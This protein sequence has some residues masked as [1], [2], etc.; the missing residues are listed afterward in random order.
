MSLEQYCFDKRP[1][2]QSSATSVSD[3]ILALKS[4]HVG[5]VIVEE[6]ARL[7][8]IVTDRDLA[9][10]VLGAK[11]EPGSMTLHDVMTPAPVTLPI[12]ASESQVVKL[13][14]AHHIR[15]IPIVDGTKVA[16]IV[17]LDDLLMSGAVNIENAGA[18]IEAQLM[19]PAANKP[20]G[21]VYPMRLPPD[22]PEQQSRARRGARAQP[23][24]DEFQ[25]LLRS[26]LGMTDP[27]RARTAFEIVV[28]ALTR[29]VTEEET[30]DLVARLPWALKRQLRELTHDASASID[31]DDLE[32]ELAHRLDLDQAAANRMLHHVVQALS[33]LLG[34]SEL[35]RLAN[36]V[37]F[38]LKRVLT[39]SGA[40]A[41]REPSRRSASG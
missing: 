16:G 21:D 30:E 7:V 39:D 25:E 35:A 18:I 10:R 9:T 13:M 19:E 31:A 2:I 27:D 34:E 40:I 1:L 41:R 14:R 33:S 20:V 28:S 32:H 29:S 38:G 8:G 26:S 36:R 12:D 15:R 3:A 5:A 6:D 11:L 22:R 24:L 4:N 23:T 17:T 37:P